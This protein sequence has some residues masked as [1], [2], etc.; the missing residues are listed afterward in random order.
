MDGVVSEDAA[1]DIYGVALK[2]ENRD[3]DPEATDALRR[4][5]GG[6]NGRLREERRTASGVEED[7]DSS[8]PRCGPV[9]AL[10]G[11]GQANAWEKRT[12]PPTEAGPLMGDLKGRYV[13]EKLYCPSCKALLKSHMVSEEH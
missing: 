2:P 10:T 6:G 8:C 1:R 7:P 9:T 4:R 3:V 13:F 12:F 5:L 11:S